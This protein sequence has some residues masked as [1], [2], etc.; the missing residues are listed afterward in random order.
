MLCEHHPKTR[1]GNVKMVSVLT[2][3]DRHETRFKKMIE[4]QPDKA[5]QVATCRPSRILDDLG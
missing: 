2:L 4:D 3:I 1:R 5:M